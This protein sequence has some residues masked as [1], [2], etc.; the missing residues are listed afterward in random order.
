MPVTTDSSN[1]AISSEHIHALLR[2]QPHEWN[3]VDKST[4][5]TDRS[6]WSGGVHAML[7][8]CSS[9][10]LTPNQRRRHLGAVVTSARALASVIVTIEAYRTAARIAQPDTAIAGR[11]RRIGR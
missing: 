5:N 6:P 8:I 1:S 11:G 10:C 4:M 7:L 2:G 3:A 9:G